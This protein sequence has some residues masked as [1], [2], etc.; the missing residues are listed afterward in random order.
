MLDTTDCN[1][2]SAMPSHPIPSEMLR[3]YCCERVSC[4]R[5]ASDDTAA[6]GESDGRLSTLP[7]DICSWICCSLPRLRCRFDITSE[8]RV[9]C[10]ILKS[11]T[12]ICL[13][14]G[15]RA[16]VVDERVERLV[17]DRHVTRRGR[18]RLLVL[19]QRH[20]LLVQIHAGLRLPVGIDLRRHL[21]LDRHL[22]V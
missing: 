14:C 11:E 15:L 2:L 19:E 1:V 5:N 7:D 13:L 21:V 10:V 17:D 6:V 20:H 22:T 16:R 4:D 3:W 12:A 8:L 9:R 18:V